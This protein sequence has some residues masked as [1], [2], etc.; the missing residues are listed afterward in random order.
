YYC[1]ITRTSQDGALTILGEA[2]TATSFQ[3]VAGVSD[4][5]LPPD[6][7]AMSTIECITSGFFDLTFTFKDIND[8]DFRAARTF[9]TNQSPVDELYWCIIGEPA[10]MRL[11]PTIDRTLDLRITYERAIPD[12]A[13]DSDRLFLPDPLDNAVLDYATYFALRQDRSP[14]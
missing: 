9:E 6:F 7:K 8:P 11:T 10:V 12:M 3:I 13:A 14:D 1:T 2:Y 5:T 4:Y